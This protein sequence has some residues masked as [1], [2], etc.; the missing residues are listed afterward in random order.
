MAK[1]FW[2]YK[3]ENDNWKLLGDGSSQFINIFPESNKLSVQYSQGEYIFYI[4]D[5]HVFT[6]YASSLVPENSNNG[7]L[8]LY[9]N[10]IGSL[11]AQEILV[12]TDLDTFEGVVPKVTPLPD[13]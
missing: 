8:G 13:P 7:M 3:R 9:I 6:Y 4:N 12:E 11:I 1:S 10:G 2:I 5:M